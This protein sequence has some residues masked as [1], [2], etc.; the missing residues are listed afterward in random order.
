MAAIDN[1]MISNILNATTPTGASGAPGS[2]SAVGGTAMKVR[3]NST[4]STA[5]AA[6]TE[7]ASG[8][9]YTTGGTA[10]P[11]AS[12]ASSAGSS[13]TLPASSALSWTNSSGGAWSIVSMDLTSSR[14]HPD[15]VR[16]LQRPADLRRERKHVPDR[17]RRRHDQPIVVNCVDC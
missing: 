12:T 16:E 2:F 13:V 4:A 6:G 14:R 15:V 3:L 7:I 8:G 1:T 10:V 9:G 11:A 17:C 5:S